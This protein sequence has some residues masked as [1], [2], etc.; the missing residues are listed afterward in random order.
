VHVEPAFAVHAPFVHEKAAEPV[1]GATESVTVNTAPDSVGLAVALHALAPTVQL[2]AVATQLTGLLA[3]SAAQEA[4]AGALH[5]PLLQTKFAAPV[6]PVMS[7]SKILAPDT[8]GAADALQV[9]PPTVQDNAVEAQSTA[10]A[11]QDALCAEPQAPLLQ[12]KFAEPVV[13]NTSCNTV[14]APELATGA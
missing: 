5:A 4:E 10:A 14:L 3:T 8:A 1:V 11:L 12:V 6:V 7:C 13:P 9:L 2:S